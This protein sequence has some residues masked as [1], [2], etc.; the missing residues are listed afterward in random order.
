MNILKAFF[1]TLILSLSNYN[2]H[3]QSIIRLA[4]N[5][6]FDPVAAQSLRLTPLEGNLILGTLNNSPLSLSSFS[7]QQRTTQFVPSVSIPSSPRVAL[8]PDGR[9]LVTLALSEDISLTLWEIKTG[10]IFSIPLTEEESIALIEDQ[11]RPQNIN[12]YLNLQRLEWVSSTEFVIR[13][14]DLSVRMGASFLFQQS[15]SL[16][17]NPLTVTRQDRIEYGSELYE[18]LGNPVTYNFYS[19]SGTYLVQ[20]GLSETISPISTIIQIVNLD[21][22]I[23]VMTLQPE[24][25]SGYIHRGL[26]SSN[27][28]LFLRQ[29]SIVNNDASTSRSVLHEIDF[30]MNPPQIDTRMWDT[31]ESALGGEVNWLEGQFQAKFSPSGAKFS[32]KAKLSGTDNIYLI[33]YTL[34]TGEI[35]AVCDNQ[36][37]ESNFIQSFWSPDERYV[38]YFEDARHVLVVMDTQEAAIYSLPLTENDQQFLGWIP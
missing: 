18:I 32:L 37:P 10:N 38:G 7:G 29:D 27:N 16:T 6:I 30:S 24:G 12:R 2:Y 8:S 15:F 21:T 31:I 23:I 28:R 4:C 19:P 17:F 33:S 22:N 20:E 1:I 35:V 34:N 25:E 3:A 36:R 13:K 5:P 26:W 9:Y 11:S 14:L